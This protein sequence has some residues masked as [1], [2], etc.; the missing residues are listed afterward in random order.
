M[1]LINYA[2]VICSLLLLFVGMANAQRIKPK[3]YDLYV[4][5][6]GKDTL[7]INFK[8]RLQGIPYQPCITGSYNNTLITALDEHGK[9]IFQTSIPFIPKQNDAYPFALPA[10]KIYCITA[11]A[12]DEKF[13]S[14]NLGRI[15]V[16]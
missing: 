9:A 1:P 15:V 8:T 6:F 7:H 3:H 2:R 10:E 13:K 14:R 4:I 16:K 11:E 12:V 5:Q